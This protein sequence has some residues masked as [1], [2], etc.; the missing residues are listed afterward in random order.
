MRHPFTHLPTEDVV[1]ALVTQQDVLVIPGTAFTP[2]DRGML[3]VSIGNLDP[4]RLADLIG[5]LAEVRAG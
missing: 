2:D 4:A 1:R 5:R 3:R